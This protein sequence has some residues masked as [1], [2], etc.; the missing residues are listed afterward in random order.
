[1]NNFSTHTN[2]DMHSRIGALELS[3]VAT[4]FDDG[5]LEAARPITAG[6]TGGRFPRPCISDGVLEETCGA[7]APHTMQRFPN[8]VCL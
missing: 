2:A 6:P 1:M 3:D 5:T 7:L 4:R 8:T